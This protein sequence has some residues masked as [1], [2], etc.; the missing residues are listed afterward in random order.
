MANGD[1]LESIMA[2]GRLVRQ[3]ALMR[4]G[5]LGYDFE[6]RDIADEYPMRI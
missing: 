2:I 3:A 1:R 6:V 4:S 5:R